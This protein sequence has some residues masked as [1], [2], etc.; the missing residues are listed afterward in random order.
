M[1]LLNLK[2][3]KF[4]ILFLLVCKNPSPTYAQ[5]SSNL[6]KD[7][8]STILLNHSFLGFSVSPYIA[9]KAKAT[10]I[11]GNYHLKTVYQ[12]GFEAGA[13][14]HFNFNTNYSL[15]VGLHGGAAARTFKLFISK[16]DFNPNLKFDVNETPQTNRIWDFYINAPIWIEKHW[17]MKNNNFWNVLFGVNVRY[18]P[19]RIY[20]EGFGVNY[21]DVNGNYVQVVDINDSIGNN[22]HP[23]V[24]F[25][26][27]GGY[28][29]LLRNNNYLQCNLL[30]N[31]SSKKMVGGAYRINVTGKQQSTGAYSANLSYV[32][33]SLSYLFTGVNKR[34]RKIYESKMK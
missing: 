19:I 21:P 26:I 28:S 11:S 8:I 29:L 13:D 23:W 30:A 3:I 12:E 33:L 2:I 9:N 16:S 10:P 14:Y 7:K 1:N 27:G 20:R 17:L 34:L 31:F 24:N 6:K 32:G 22:F 25:N 5:K 15:I 4:I 18:Y